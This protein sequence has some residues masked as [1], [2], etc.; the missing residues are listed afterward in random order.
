MPELVCS[1][2]Q[3]LYPL[4]THEWRCKCGSPFN[5]GGM[6]PFAR[7]AVD[8]SV[9]SLWRYR[10]MLPI[11]DDEH[12][13]SLGEGM[14]PLIVTD[15][16]G[17]MV[18]CKL[19]FLAP[20]GSFKDRG[21]TVLVSALKEMGVE[22]VVEDS[23]GN[24][25]AS[26]AAY[27]AH[28]GIRAR[29][30]VPA[31]AS[32]AKK[33]QIA[34]YG[35]QVVSVEGSRHQ[36]TLAAQKAARN[37]YYASHFYNPFGLAGT[38]TFAYEICEQLGWKA[39]GSVIFPAGHGT[40]LLGSYWGFRDLLQAGVINHLP[41]LFAVQ[42]AAC[43]PLY[44]AY[45]RGMDE[46]PEVQ[47]GDTVAEGIRI[48][49]PVRGPA[50]LRAVRDTGGSVVMVDDWETLRGREALARQGLYVEP[51]SAVVVPAMHKLDKVIGGDEI[52]VVPLTGSG[53]KVPPEM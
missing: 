8:P 51:T 49:D 9:T 3:R 48:V 33:D 37:A 23:S 32:A 41:R 12:I 29:I 42:S 14:T 40:L 31:Y 44:Q 22:S 15:L 13:V 1:S 34:Y 45:S 47:V 46:I 7:D 50:V 39:P 10:A 17:Q 16:Y 4:D 21:T 6:P 24:A 36:A 43:S 52:T 18:H 30:F 35:A 38:R 19:E 28:A 20:T 27:C 2:C 53:L 26:L 5:L 11:E 25:A